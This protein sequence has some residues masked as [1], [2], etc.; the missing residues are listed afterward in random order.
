MLELLET[1]AGLVVLGG[2]LAAA[3][4]LPSAVILTFALLI[5]LLIRI[6]LVDPLVRLI[7]LEL[8]A[9]GALAAAGR[10]AR[11][12]FLRLAGVLVFLALVGTA[13]TGPSANVLA[14][15]LSQTLVTLT[16]IQD[17]VAKWLTDRVLNDMLVELQAAPGEGAAA[18]LRL[19]ENMVAN[20]TYAALQPPVTLLAFRWTFAAVASGLAGLYLVY[21]PAR[22]LRQRLAG[23]IAPARA[24]AALSEESLARQAELIAQVLA[25]AAPAAPAAPAAAAAAQPR[26]AQ[27]GQARPLAP[28]AAPAEAAATSRVA[29]VTWDGELAGAIERQLDSAGFAP[30]LMRSVAEACAARVWPSLVFIDARH[31]AWLSPDR[32]PLAVRARLVAVT[33]E[34]V[35]VPEG[36]QLDTHPVESGADSLLELLRR[37]EARRKGAPR[38]G[39]A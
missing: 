24:E 4:V 22:A 6:A 35:R 13:S 21:E 34:G 37:R 25:R 9:I 30:L 36:W 1:V 10:A 3:V 23:A 19:L 11:T 15:G 38:E 14:D 18:S 17:I 12:A 33:R 7:P 32:L 29:I 28:R 26:F 5:G 27:P 39:G 8:R 31:L 16:A 20:R 2:Y